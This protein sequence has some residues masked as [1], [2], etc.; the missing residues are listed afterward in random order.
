MTRR[1]LA[2]LAAGALLA[3]VASLNTGCSTLAMQQEIK[4]LRARV[5]E[6]EAEKQKELNELAAAKDALIEQLS[7]E[8]ADNEVKLRMAQQ[9]LVVTVM[10]SV[11]F[12][13]GKADLKPEA[14]ATLKKIA[15]VIKQK[16]PDNE[17]AFEGH[18]DNV[19]IHRPC[20]PSNWEL[21]TARATSVLHYFVDELGFDPKKLRAVGFGEF[22][23]VASNDTPEGR[24][25][26]RRTEIV[27]LPLAMSRPVG[28]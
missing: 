17:I 9:G 19:P 28:E 22:R 3:A 26:N 1:N 27:I 23:P 16:A 18:T 10:D 14:K 4:T 15:E 20:F 7:S 6:L 25:K 13:S 5:A 2:T 12:D 11:L 21:S 8:I 24:Q